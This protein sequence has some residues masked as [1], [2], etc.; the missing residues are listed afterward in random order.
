MRNKYFELAEEQF[1]N[2][3]ESTLDDDRKA[4]GASNSEKY[5]IDGVDITIKVDGCWEK[6]TWF[7]WF[8]YDSNGAILYQGT[9]F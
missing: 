7:D 4:I 9:E 2:L 3:K 5:T 1:Y 6:S 8:I